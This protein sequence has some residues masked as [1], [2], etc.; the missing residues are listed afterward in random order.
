MEK[1]SSKIVHRIRAFL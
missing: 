1:Q